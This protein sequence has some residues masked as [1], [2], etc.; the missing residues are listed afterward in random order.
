MGQRLWTKDFLFTTVSNLFLFF[1]FQMLIPTLPVYTERLG[2]DEFAVGMVIGIFTISALL[3]RPFAGK[4]LDRYNRRNVLIIG[5]IIFISS[6]ISYHWVTTV[7]IILSLRFIHGIGWGITTTSYGTIIA[8]IIPSKRRGEGMGYYGLSSTL[9]MAIAP[10]LGIWVMNVYGFG[11]LFFLS[12]VL[13]ITALIF[14]QFIRYSPP[15]PLSKD[16]EGVKHKDEDMRKNSSFWEGLI[17]K[18]ALFPS[19]LVML[20]SVTY[21]GVVS[22]ITLFGKEVGIENVGWFFLANALMVMVVRPISG[23]IFDRKGHAWVLF[24]G[25]ISAIIGLGLLSFTTNTYFL[26]LSALFYGLGFGTIQPSLQAWTINRVTSQRRGAA[27]GT[28]FSAFDLGIGIGSMLL[29]M[30]AKASSYAIMYRISIVLLIVYLIFYLRYIVKK[31]SS[32]LSY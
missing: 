13:A 17:E 9:G 4:A 26:V 16:S 2:G 15:K 29:G 19:F 12:M 8:D 27:N 28:F 30:V 22:F 20:F 18:E 25:V 24:P 23:V 1:S 3:T 5:L 32:H 7:L 21:G 10:L 14:S 11:L 31:K 6:V